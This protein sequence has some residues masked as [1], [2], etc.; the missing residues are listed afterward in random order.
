MIIRTNPNSA[1]PIKGF[2]T[3]QKITFK[4]PFISFLPAH[5][6]ECTATAT[7]VAAASSKQQH[8]NLFPVNS[9]AGTTLGNLNSNRIKGYAA[10]LIPHSTEHIH[11]S[12]I[13][14]T[15]MLVN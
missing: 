10:V 9:Y 8:S 11:L 14:L 5:A 1:H 6:D 3:I 2:S 13:M 15:Q 7:I 4:L 12:V